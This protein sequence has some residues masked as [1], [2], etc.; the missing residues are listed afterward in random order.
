MTGVPASTSF[1]PFPQPLAKAVLSGHFLLR[2]PTRKTECNSMPFPLHDLSHAHGKLHTIIELKALKIREGQC[3][4]RV[5]VLER[6]THG[7]LS[8][9]TAK[10]SD[11]PPI[12]P[13]VILVRQKAWSTNSGKTAN[14]APIRI[15]SSSFKKSTHGREMVVNAHAAQDRMLKVGRAVQ[16]SMRLRRKKRQSVLRGYRRSV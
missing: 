12:P 6:L 15:V 14:I 1:P 3:A 8:R 11:A 13:S 9:L 7:T 2:P 5:Q 4:L 10:T 16:R